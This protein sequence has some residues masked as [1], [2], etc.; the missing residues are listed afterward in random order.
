MKKTLSGKIREVDYDKIYIGDTAFTD[1]MEDVAECSVYGGTKQHKTGLGGRTTY[2]PDCAVRMFFTSN[3]CSLDEAEIALLQK[4]YGMGYEIKDK[5][6][7]KVMSRGG[8]ETFEG[9]Y[10]SNIDL[11]GY[12]EFTII[13]YDVTTCTLGGHNL[14]NILSSHIGQYVT[15]E[16]SQYE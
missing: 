5:D 4:L 9:D 10:K 2:I 11:I 7:N 12:S 1:F 14:L 3:E 16:V 15:I 8:E 13:G 6:G